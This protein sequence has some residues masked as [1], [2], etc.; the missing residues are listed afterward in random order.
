MSTGKWELHE[1]SVDKIVDNAEQPLKPRH[2]MQIGQSFWT[3]HSVAK[4]IEIVYMNSIVCVDKI[5]DYQNNKY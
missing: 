3:R 5:V 4:S 2:W 1:V